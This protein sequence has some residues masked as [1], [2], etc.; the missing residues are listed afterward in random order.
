MAFR[1]AFYNLYYKSD[2]ESEMEMVDTCMKKK[3]WATNDVKLWMNL[4]KK[5]TLEYDTG[6]LRQNDRLFYVNR[7]AIFFLKWKKKQGVNKQNEFH[8]EFQCDLCD[9]ACEYICD[10]ICVCMFICMI[11]KPQLKKKHNKRLNIQISNA[12]SFNFSFSAA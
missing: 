8:V 11:F 6:L 1:T 7:Q 5:E 2:D 12:S 9:V 3:I 10:S 4:L